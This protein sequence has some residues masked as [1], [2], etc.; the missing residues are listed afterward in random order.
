MRK[1]NQYYIRKT[2]RWLGVLIGIQFLGWTLSGLYFTWTDLDEIHGDHFLASAKPTSVTG[3]LPIDSSMNIRSL[4]LRFIGDESYFW[5]NDSVLLDAQTGKSRGLITQEEATLIARRN[6]KAIY[7]IDSVQFITSTGPHHEYRERS[8]PAWSIAFKGSDEM[9]AY[10][11][12]KDASFQTIRHSSW[13]WFDYLWMFHTM[14]YENRDNFNNLLIRGFSLFG[15]L[16]VLSGFTLFFVTTK[17]K[18]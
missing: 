17:K 11:S 13:R 3:I 9:V 10:V 15:L 14:D 8:L 6:V 18:K 7:E 1:N 12:A 5:V 16:T 2:H 4:E